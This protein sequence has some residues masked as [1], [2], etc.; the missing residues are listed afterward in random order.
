MIAHPRSAPCMA[1]VK[2]YLATEVIAAALVRLGLHSDTG[3]SYDPGPVQSRV[4]MGM[5]V[6]LLASYF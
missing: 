1:F 4:T 6:D 3:Q 2:A 5:A